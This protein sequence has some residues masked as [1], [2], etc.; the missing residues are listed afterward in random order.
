MRSISLKREIS[1]SGEASSCLKRPTLLYLF[2]CNI[3]GT[4]MGISCT[5]SGSNPADRWDIPI[6]WWLSPPL[7]EGGDTEMGCAQAQ[8][9]KDV[10]SDGTVRVDVSWKRAHFPRTRMV[11][12]M[13]DE[14]GSLCENQQFRST[15]EESPNLK[16]PYAGHIRGISLNSRG[17]PCH[18]SH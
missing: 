9:V 18:V 4:N 15:P 6:S 5:G 17:F 13:R 12:R 3:Y 8:Q 11:R 1:A 16:G 14:S 10:G 2:L 7:T